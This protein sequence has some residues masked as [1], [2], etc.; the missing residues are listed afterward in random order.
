[1]KSFLISIVFLPFISQ[2]VIA[3]C[4]VKEIPLESGKW[5][6]AWKLRPERSTVYVMQNGTSKRLGLSDRKQ[7]NTDLMRHFPENTRIFLIINKL[8]CSAVST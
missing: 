6:L 5:E 4:K 1:M 2:T 8:T 3:D 7:I